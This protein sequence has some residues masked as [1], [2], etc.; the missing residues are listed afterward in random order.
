MDHNSLEKE[1][2]F[3]EKHAKKDPKSILFARLADS[4]KIQDSEQE[5]CTIVSDGFF[6]L[7]LAL[8]FL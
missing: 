5:F 6:P 3:L 2:T 4:V 1:I 8:T 7:V